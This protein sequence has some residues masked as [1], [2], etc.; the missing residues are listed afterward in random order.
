MRSPDLLDEVT[1]SKHN[2]S[3]SQPV[4]CLSTMLVL[5]GMWYHREHRRLTRGRSI[6]HS[7]NLGTAPKAGSVLGRPGGRLCVLP[8]VVQHVRAAYRD[9]AYYTYGSACDGAS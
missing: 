8:Y 1:D 5:V 2:L 9:D 7:F 4:Y 3:G 6:C